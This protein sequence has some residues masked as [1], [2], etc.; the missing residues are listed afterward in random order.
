VP[1]ITRESSRRSPLSIDDPGLA[2]RI[3]AGD[4]AAIEVVV[5]AYL[6]HILRAARGA[7]LDETQAEDVTQETFATFIEK[8]PS[9]H[10][11]AH[12]RT[13]LFGIFYKKVLEFRR[14]ASRSQQHDDIDE[15]VEQRFSSDG[16]WLRP[17]R[18]V[19]T[20]VYHGEI[21]EWLRECLDTVPMRQRLAFVLREAE[22][23]SSQEICNILDVTRTNL[24]AMLHRCRNRLRECLEARGIRGSRDARL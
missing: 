23:F 13:W 9:F 7:G 5:K 12:V 22:G 17:P 6:S 24:G 4:R 15:I 3:R 8:A 10:G 18:A 14:E 1:D 11:R 19:D 16:S 20:D 21:R 2:E